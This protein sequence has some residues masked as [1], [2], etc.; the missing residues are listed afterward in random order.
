MKLEDYDKGLWSLYYSEPHALEVGGEL[1]GLISD[2]FTHDVVLEVTGDF[3]TEPTHKEYCEALMEK[4][5][6]GDSDV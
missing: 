5:N 6:T 4:L 2:D 3:G 1:I